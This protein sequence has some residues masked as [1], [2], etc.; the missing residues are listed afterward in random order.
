MRTE[1]EFDLALEDVPRLVV[2]TVYML[3]RTGHARRRARLE[4]HEGPIVGKFDLDLSLRSPGPED[5]P[6]AG[7]HHSCVIV[8]GHAV[9][10]C[11]RLLEV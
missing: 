5:T 6:I 11:Q 10:P 4:H 3:R 2:F 1:I 7:Q 8:S 9:T